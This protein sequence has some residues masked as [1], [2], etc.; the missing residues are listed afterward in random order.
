M[1]TNPDILLN[2]NTELLADFD[3][4]WLRRYPIIPLYKE[5]GRICFAAANP[6][7]IEVKDQIQEALSEKVILKAADPLA[8][9]R[10]LNRHYQHSDQLQTMAG[11]L[12]EKYQQSYAKISNRSHIDL[13]SAVAESISDCM[14][15]IIAEAILHQASDIH[16]EPLETE[17]LIRFRVDGLLHEFDRLPMQFLQ[18]LV[19]YIK[20]EANMDITNMRLPQDGQIELNFKDYIFDLRITSIPTIL[21]EKLAIRLLEKQRLVLGLSDLGFRPD[22]LTMIEHEIR[23]PFGLILVSGPTGSGKT[24]TLFSVL[25]TLQSVDKNIVTIEDPVEYRLPLVNQMEIHNESGL[26]FAAAS[27]C[28]L[29][30]DPDVI[31]L[32]EIRD[33]ETAHTAIQSALAGTLLLSTI[34]SNHALGSIDR[35]I[36]FGVDR[37][38]VAAALSSVLAQ[39]L[40][41]KICPY[42]KSEYKPNPEYLAGLGLDPKGTY[43]HGAGCPACLHTGYIGRECIGEWV[44]INDDIRDA[45]YNNAAPATLMD[46]AKNGDSYYSFKDSA[47]EKIL[48]HITTVEEVA[49]VLSIDKL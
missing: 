46:I 29:R 8:I 9:Y 34:H 16:V 24:S 23:Q 22:I 20:V 33:S 10:S 31:L 17:I 40:V 25:K 12:A 19:S 38:W 21:G 37:F 41:R 47:K 3:V 28:L 13:P 1:D 32:G 5:E 2:L 42:C 15:Y 43:T 39:R 4:E 35:L 49:R 48:G 18:P 14:N 6:E 45:I 11:D 27:R 36:N 26:D 7:D 44:G 30:Q